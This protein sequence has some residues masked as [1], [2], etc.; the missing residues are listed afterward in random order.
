MLPIPQDTHTFVLTIEEPGGDGKFNVEMGRLCDAPPTYME[1]GDPRPEWGKYCHNMQWFDIR[2]FDQ[3][4]WTEYDHLFKDWRD[5]FGPM[6]PMCHLPAI[7]R[8][9]GV[10][11]G[12]WKWQAT[13]PGRLVHHLRVLEPLVETPPEP[14][15]LPA[16][17]EALTPSAPPGT[18]PAP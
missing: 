17:F 7:L 3:A 11:Y 8:G 13:I 15:R 9:S 5:R 10:Y 2:K 4:N 12:I 1:S 16:S 14:I 6:V 18:V